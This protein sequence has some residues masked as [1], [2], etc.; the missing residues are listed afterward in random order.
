MAPAGGMPPR[1]AAAAVA[2]PQATPAAAAD[3]D[4]LKSYMRVQN[5]SDVRGVAIDTNTAE[6]ITLT[7]AMMFFIGAAFAGKCPP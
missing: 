3:P 7:P 2:A 4:T 6:P 5:G 1:V